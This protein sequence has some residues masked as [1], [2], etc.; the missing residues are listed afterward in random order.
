MASLPRM[1]PPSCIDREAHSHQPECRRFSPALQSGR[2]GDIEA[3]IDGIPN[4]DRA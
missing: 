4:S 2:S 1:E 3:V